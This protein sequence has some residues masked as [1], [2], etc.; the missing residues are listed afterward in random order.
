MLQR[1][2]CR[3]CSAFGGV[4]IGFHIP[5]NYIFAIQ[6][7]L[8]ER[9]CCSLEHNLTPSSSCPYKLYSTSAVKYP[10]RVSC[11]DPEDDEELME[12]ELREHFPSYLHE[13]FGEFVHSDLNDIVKPIQAKSSSSG[14]KVNE[15]LMQDDYR[16]ICNSFMG[17]IVNM[18]SCYFHKKATG[19]GVDMGLTAVDRR[20]AFGLK[21]EI[22]KR[23]FEQ[24]KS[25]LSDSL[26]DAFYLGAGTLVDTI[27]KHY[28]ET[29]I[30][31]R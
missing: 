11:A 5:L 17:T 30:T 12:A 13:D 4:P 31:G 23:L 21:A 24:F 22:F 3:C 27:Q 7:S 19:G 9:C 14:G 2:L 25:T 15:V 26:D 18:T 1:S 8:L 29:P 28:E 16:L 20:A 10:C 6:K